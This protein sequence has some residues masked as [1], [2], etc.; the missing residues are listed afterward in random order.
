MS[1]AFQ[2]ISGPNLA[3][4]IRRKDNRLTRD[5]EAGEPDARILDSLYWSLLTRPPTRAETEGILN[6]FRS[7]S[8]RRAVYEDL[9]W[10]LMN[11]KEFLFR[12]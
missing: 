5:L 7:G 1:Q 2:M 6:H 4:L 8:E 9:L 3:D 12:L 10:A 11:S